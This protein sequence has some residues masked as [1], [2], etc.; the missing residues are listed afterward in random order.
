MDETPETETTPPERPPATPP[1]TSASEA[2]DAPR[3]SRPYA[4][5]ELR[6]ATSLLLVTTG[7]GKGKSTAAFG[8]A[9]RSVA[10]GW[11]TAVVQYL[12]SGTW[13]TGEEKLGRQVGIDWFAAGDGFTWDSS[14][15][16][17]T[18]AK[19]VAGWAFTRELIAAG[20]HRLIVLD[21]ISYPM[22]WGWV[23]VDEVVTTLTERPED[24]SLFLTGRRMPQAVIDVADTVTEMTK[25]KH[26]FDTGI[27]ARRGIDY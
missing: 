12:K 9:M 17:E 18:Q 15:L 19:A 26:A 13:R 25:V 6:S 21:E 22:V 2:P 10:R 1:T 23:D 24:V 14:D 3:S 5:E 11:P 27:R 7:D 20:S 4:R 8:T 16:D